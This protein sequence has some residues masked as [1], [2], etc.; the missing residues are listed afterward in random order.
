MATPV[1]RGMPKAKRMLKKKMRRWTQTKEKN[2][3]EAGGLSIMIRGKLLVQVLVTV[4]C[5]SI[6]DKCNNQHMMT[7]THLIVVDIG[8]NSM[9]R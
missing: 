2:W 5:R 9:N 6:P 1:D 8:P 7:F 4:M 3:R